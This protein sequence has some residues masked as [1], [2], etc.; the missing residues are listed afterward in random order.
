MRRAARGQARGIGKFAPPAKKAATHT[1]CRNTATK[2]CSLL[3]AGYNP[4]RPSVQEAVQPTKQKACSAGTMKLR[5]LGLVALLTVTTAVLGFL[6]AANIV[7]SASSPEQR[8]GQS[9]ASHAQEVAPASPQSSEPRKLQLIEEVRKRASACRA[10]VWRVPACQVL[11]PTLVPCRR[12]RVDGTGR[13]ACSSSD[14]RR[15]ATSTSTTGPSNSTASRCR[16]APLSLHAVP[17]RL[18]ASAPLRPMRRC[19]LLPSH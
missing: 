4:A 6:L 16:S 3:L 5:P 18:R 2:L 11:M 8:R 14:S 9:R 12:Q 19:A 13:A 17:P 15:A 7:V 1:A 10:W